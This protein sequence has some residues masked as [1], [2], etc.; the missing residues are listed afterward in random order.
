M[1]SDDEH[2]VAARNPRF[3]VL[4]RS[5]W[6]RVAGYIWLLMA[7]KKSRHRVQYAALP[8]RHEAG[9]RL[10]V[11]LLTSRETRRWIIPKGW[12]IR[13]R[14]PSEVAAQEAFEEAGLVGTI[15][16]K[17]PSGR[18]HYEKQLFPNRGILCEVTVHLLLVERQLDDWPE[19]AE[20]EMQWSDPS[21]TC[22]LV[23]EGALAEILRRMA[24]PGV[25]TGP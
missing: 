13:G 9:G 2:A 14:E 15:V 17:H 18:Y 11:T 20:R 6:R 1:D 12:P 25:C 7:K 3:P 5:D 10:C 22:N 19:K 23:D 21:D 16:S 8:I 24:D 4:V